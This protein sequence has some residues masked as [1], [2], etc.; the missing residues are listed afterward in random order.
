L[1]KKYTALVDDKHIFGFQNVAPVVKKS[2]LTGT[3]GAL[4]KQ[5]LNAVSAK[6]TLKAMQ[7]MNKAVVIDK[8]SIA[9]V[10]KKFLQAN[11][12]A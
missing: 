9:T 11:G 2:L 3:G 10:A 8:I 6:L 5:T 12:L 1:Q 4:I 7:Q